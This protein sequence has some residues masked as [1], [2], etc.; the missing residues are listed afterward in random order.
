MNDIHVCRFSCDIYVFHSRKEG[1]REFQKHARRT[2]H[3]MHKRESV[4]GEGICIETCWAMCF[5]T[6]S[7][8]L[9]ISFCNTSAEV[10]SR[11]LFRGDKD[12]AS[13][14]RRVG[15]SL[16]GLTFAPPFAIR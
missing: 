8:R 16:F 9:S 13:A 15:E 1:G 14:F 12:P 10:L 3:E 6:S 5:M 2:V 7:S 11:P 4:E